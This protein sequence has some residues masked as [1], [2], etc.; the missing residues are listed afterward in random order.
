MILTDVF[1]KTADA[2]A[3]TERFISSCGGTRSGKTI[4][5]LQYLFLLVSQDKEPTINSVV[6]ETYP[7]LKRGAIRDFQT[8]IDLYDE[9]CWSKGASTYTF[10]SGAIIEFFSADSPAKVHGPARDRLFLNEC[11]NINWEVAR[12]LFVRTR[13]LV[14]LD[15]NPTAS[16]WVNEKIEP[17]DTCVKIHSTY[18]DNKD[19]K[20]G[21]STL[22]PE[23]VA[24][25]ESNRNDAN[26]W[27]VYG[28]GLQGRLE[29][30][31]F[32]DFEQID[33]LP[34][35]SDG[36][37]ETYGWDF[38]F[39]NDPSVLMHTLVDTR[40]KVI[41]TDEVCYRKGLLN[42][43]MADVMKSEKIGRAIPV[44][45]DSAEPKTI[46]DLH[47]YGYNML[48]AYKAVRK[49]EQLQAMKGYSI[50]VT[51]RSLNT[52]RELRSYTWAKDKNGNW[53]NEPIELNDHCMDSLRY[54]CYQYLKQLQPTSSRFSR[55]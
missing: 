25:I 41:Y 12:Q 24:E 14:F 44:F 26:W 36:M 37:V 39:T 35:K 29:G 15:Y 3:V 55:T 19:Y 33:Q 31:I 18:L 10:P 54:S 2:S 20:T 50:K 52:I 53:L 5:I 28:L 30:L 27:Q 40:K 6:S 11:Q 7:H 17:R 1:M 51:K 22:S 21:V 46:E 4:S 48:P 45:G 8:T 49:A 42:A 34:E 13:G 47:R 23:Q 38:G 32:P 9:T 43:D 16:F